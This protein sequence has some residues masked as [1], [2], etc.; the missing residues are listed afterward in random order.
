MR[1]KP[2]FMQV[3]KINFKNTLRNDRYYN[4]NFPVRI[5]KEQQEDRKDGK[6]GKADNFGM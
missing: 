1:E 2:L 6:Y 4:L 3:K 5:N